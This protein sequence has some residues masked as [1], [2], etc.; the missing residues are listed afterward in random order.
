[1]EEIAG[2]LDWSCAHENAFGVATTLYERHPVTNENAGNPIADCFAVVARENS[3]I[4]ALADGVNW[5]EKA[6][7]AARSAIHGCVEYLN[8]A[9]FSPSVAAS[10]ASNTKVFEIH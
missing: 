9:L 8:K 3:A 10:H 6:C 1:M 4:L 5:G 2:I 7:V